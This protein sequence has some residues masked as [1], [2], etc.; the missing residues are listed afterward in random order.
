MPIMSSTYFFCY[1]LFNTKLIYYLGK[2]KKYRLKKLGVNIILHKIRLQTHGVNIAGEPILTFLPS[3]L[4]KMYVRVRTV[5]NLA[6]HT[7]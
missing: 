6:I 1:E 7:L 3:K 2:K 4:K 5:Q